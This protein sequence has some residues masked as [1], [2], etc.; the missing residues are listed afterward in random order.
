SG[1][2]SNPQSPADAPQ[3]AQRIKRRAQSFRGRC[4]RLAAIVLAKPL[5][6]FFQ[7]LLAGDR[8]L[9]HIRTLETDRLNRLAIAL[10]M[11]TLRLRLGH[12]GIR[13]DV[14][15]E[16]AIKINTADI[17]GLSRVIPVMPVFDRG[18]VLL[19]RD[20]LTP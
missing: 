5:A 1:R 10:A 4:N 8:P 11:E 13:T 17:A 14:A 12:A 19:W 18:A 15:G 6:Y 16:N 20:H 2:L 9:H 3:N 7:W